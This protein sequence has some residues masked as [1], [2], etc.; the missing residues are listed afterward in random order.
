ML[1]ARLPK[2]RCQRLIFQGCSPPVYQSQ[3]FEF[4]APGLLVSTIPKPGCLSL[5]LKNCSSAECLTHMHC[6]QV[7]RTRH[8][9]TICL[10]S[11]RRCDQGT[12]PSGVR[13]KKN[14]PHRF[15]FERTPY[16][17]LAPHLNVVC[18]AVFWG[19]C[20]KEPLSSTPHRPK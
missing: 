17:P 7:P 16:S 1:Y 8:L 13:L 19:E 12:R 18:K 5:I 11:T 14:H 10:W 3:V 6:R 4:G 2:P 15:G 9:S 20:K